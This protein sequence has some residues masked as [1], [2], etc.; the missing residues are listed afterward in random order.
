MYRQTNGE[1]EMTQESRNDSSNVSGNAGMNGSEQT[2]EQ[3]SEQGSAQTNEQTGGQAPDQAT[4]QAGTEESRTQGAQ[5][6]EPMSLSEFFLSIPQAL[7][8][9]TWRASSLKWTLGAMLAVESDR[10]P[11]RIWNRAAAV[12]GF[13]AGGL[14]ELFGYMVTRV[15]GLVIAIGWL[16]ACLAGYLLGLP[17]RL[18]AWI[19]LR[20]LLRK[21][22]GGWFVAEMEAR[23]ASRNRGH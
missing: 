18:A 22:H 9:L 21:A 23:K 2:S 7:L 14:V 17:R 19:R 11:A 12:L 8:V 5:T 10:L 6:E 3:T 15:T 4:D 20:L 1:H 16:L 13:L